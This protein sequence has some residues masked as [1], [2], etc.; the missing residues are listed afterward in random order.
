LPL[1]VASML[2]SVSA[3]MPRYFIQHFLGSR[4]LGIYSALSYIPAGCIMVAT[5]LGQAVFA[6]L[7]KYYYFGQTRGFSL[8]LAKSSLFCGGVGMLVLVVSALF[9][10]TIL[11]NLYR[12]EYAEHTELLLWL[13]AG[14]AVGCVAACFGCGMTA[15]L[16]FKDQVLLLLI[17]LASSG[18]ACAVLIPRWGLLGAAV[19]ALISM[20]TQLL[21]SAAILFH[22]LRTRTPQLQGAPAE[23]LHPVLE[24]DPEG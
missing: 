5:A 15:A 3:N 19:A 12:A 11:T 4:E 16:H 20:T 6:R 21:G 8:L 17:V 7:S 14:A 24:A 1:G 2:I 18:I 9:G 10:R 23:R 22:G 13:A